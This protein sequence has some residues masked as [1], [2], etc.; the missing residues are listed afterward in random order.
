LSKDARDRILLMENK[1]IALALILWLSKYAQLT[2][3]NCSLLIAIS[4]Y[5]NDLG[6]KPLW[7]TAR[8]ARD[9]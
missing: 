7:Y 9:P 5:T 1:S 6:W 8:L 2:F 3:R 4:T